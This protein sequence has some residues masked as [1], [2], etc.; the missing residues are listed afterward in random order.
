[1][2]IA[3]LK[4]AIGQFFVGAHPPNTIPV[5]INVESVAEHSHD[6]DIDCRL[7]RTSRQRHVNKA[8]EVALSL[9]S[10]NTSDAF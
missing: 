8:T 9:S 7:Q 6:C 3:S 10:F 1:M 5:G 4:D 2:A